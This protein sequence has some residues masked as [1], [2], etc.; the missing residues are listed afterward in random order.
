MNKKGLIV[1]ILFLIIILTMFIIY[2]NRDNDNKTI[3]ISNYIVEKY[4]KSYSYEIVYSENYN[5]YG[6]VYDDSLNDILYKTISLFTYDIK[7]NDLKFIDTVSNERIVNYRIINQDVYYLKICSIDKGYKWEL[8]KQN[9]IENKSNILD[10][11]TISSPISYPN[12]FLF[13]DDIILA[14]ISDLSEYQKFY[15]KKYKD[16]NSIILYETRGHKTKKDGQLAFNLDNNKLIDKH[17]YYTIID[18]NNEQIL[19]DYDLE[20]NTYNQKFVNKEADYYLQDYYF[21]DDNSYI[22]LADRNDFSKSKM[23]INDITIY[24]TGINT[25]VKKLNDTSLIFHN[26]GDVW[27]ILDFE[28][29]KLN[30][31]NIVDFQ[32]FPNYYIIDN[33]VILVQDLYNNDAYIVNFN[34]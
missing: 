34:Y 24:D 23:I 25:F 14:I 6:I 28:T 9:L 21:F 12:M 13:K 26:T 19:Y 22:L 32:T 31:V 5:V 17:I 3:Q 29:K 2:Y 11:G 1:I 7:N 16:N 30:E 33:N 4:G 8:V 10:S 18:E 27:Q 20:T 15:I